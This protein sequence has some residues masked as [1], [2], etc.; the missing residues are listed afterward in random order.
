MTSCFFPKWSQQWTCR[1][2]QESL[3]QQV[4]FLPSPFLEPQQVPDCFNQE[5]AAEVIPHDCHMITK[6]DMLPPG[7]LALRT[8]ALE[9]S[10][11]A[12]K[13]PKR[14]HM[15][16][17]NGED[18]RPH[19][20]PASTIRYA[21]ANGPSMDSSLPHPSAPHLWATPVVHR[22]ALLNPAQTANS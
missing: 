8:L 22:W 7:P 4:T 10:N 15:D 2:L 5:N 6:G 18:L 1:T 21:R 20:L 9:S 13:K 16:R 17:W 14:G 11:H 3:P 12:V 19:P